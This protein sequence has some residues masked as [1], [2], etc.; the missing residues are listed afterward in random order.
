MRLLP[1]LLLALVVTATAA[2]LPFP[3]PPWMDPD[4]KAMQGDWEV[5]EKSCGGLLMR[6]DDVTLRIR[7]DRMMFLVEGDVRTV[8]AVTTKPVAE[9]KRMDLRCV[10][11][12]LTGSIGLASLAVYRID[13]DRLTVA[14]VDAESGKDRPTDFEGKRRGEWLTTYKRKVP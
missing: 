10:G 7:G 12:T 1:A 14:D 8:W 11:G 9:P 3:K 5:V 6:Q 2:P 4:L 13:G